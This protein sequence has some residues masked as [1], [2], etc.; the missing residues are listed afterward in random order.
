MSEKMNVLN[1]QLDSC[2]AKDAMKIITEYLQTESVNTVE[3]V[4]V[5][6]L[7][8]ASQ[9]EGMKE[10]LEQL[11]LVLAGDAAIL[12]VAKI[13]DERLVQEA[14][15]QTLMKMVLRYFHKNHQKIFILAGSA[16]EGQEIRQYLQDEYGG[17]EVV[18]CE[19]V[20]EDESRDDQVTN[21]INGVESCCVLASME[22]P[23]QEQF[24]HRC[25]EQINTRL[26]LGI[27]RDFAIFPHNDNLFNRFKKFVGCKFLKREIKKEQKR[28]EV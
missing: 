2:T 27:G 19:I 15:N 7:M 16:E 6:T 26:W 17:I 14:K 18:G 8:R 24:I 3:L 28:K 23:G 4:T 13:T 9:L 20:P 12:D 21:S 25:R 22:S 1:V 5:N 11:D 10:E